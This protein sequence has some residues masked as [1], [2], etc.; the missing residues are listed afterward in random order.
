MP[1]SIM[2]AASSAR[3]AA[4]QWRSKLRPWAGAQR[5]LSLVTVLAGNRP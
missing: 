5:G 1:L 4:G 2:V 3:Q